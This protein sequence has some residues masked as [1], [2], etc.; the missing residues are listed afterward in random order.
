MQVS[1]LLNRGIKSCSCE[2]VAPLV[3]NVLRLTVT[4]EQM[5]TSLREKIRV[6]SRLDQPIEIFRAVDFLR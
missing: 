2:R 6:M 5:Y 3:R 4:F 1:D